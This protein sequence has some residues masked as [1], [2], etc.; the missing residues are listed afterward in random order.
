MA[1]GGWLDSWAAVA[2]YRLAG[3][4]STARVFIWAGG[5][6]AA[7]VTYLLEGVAEALFILR[8][9]I[10]PV[11]LRTLLASADV[12]PFFKASFGAL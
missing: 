11:L 10:P 9:K 6:G 8:M 5:V 3:P 4:W 7:R 2:C 12:I 1:W